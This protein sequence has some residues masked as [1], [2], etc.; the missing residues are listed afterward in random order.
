MNTFRKFYI[1][2]KEKF[3]GYLLRKTGNY[4]LSA[5]I[6]QESF[7]RYLERYKDREESPALLFTIGR[8]LLYD[9]FRKN[10]GDT[11]YEDELH[12][13]G[14]GQ[15]EAYGIKEEYQGVLRAMEKLDDEER[16]ILSLVVSSNL[17]YR[18]IAKITGNSEGNIKVKI[19]RSRTKL[20]TIL[21]QGQS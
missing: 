16:D 9:H 7:T 1:E 13:E 20:K 15:E 18:E 8:N 21:R 17:S 10:R 14:T 3:F 11:S 4:H 5:D 6:M 12:G 2:N 19:H